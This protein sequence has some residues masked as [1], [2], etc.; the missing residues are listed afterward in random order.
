MPSP[1]RHEIISAAVGTESAVLDRIP[2]DYQPRQARLFQVGLGWLVCELVHDPS[3]R[4]ALQNSLLVLERF[5]EGQA[6][7]HDLACFRQPLELLAQARTPLGSA[8]ALA[9]HL[10]TGSAQRGDLFR[11][12][13][14]VG[15][16]VS[17]LHS[18]PNELVTLQQQM[19]DTANDIWPVCDGTRCAS[20]HWLTPEVRQ[21]C[22]LM[23]RQR[24]LNLFPVLGDAL[25]EAGCTDE[26]LLSHCYRPIRHVRGCWL[27]DLLLGASEANCNSKSSIIGENYSSL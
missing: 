25:L 19:L 7:A 24:R 20:R 1:Q 27:L 21:L 23:L 16:L 26:W 3:C 4:S 8:Y 10:L 11:T 13:Q 9:A 15:R 6:T 2:R 14:S 22:Q 18:G 12:V 17:I 5:A